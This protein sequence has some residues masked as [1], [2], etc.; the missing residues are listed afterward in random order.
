LNKQNALRYTEAIVTFIATIAKTHLKIN[1]FVHHHLRRASCSL[2]QRGEQGK[3]KRKPTMSVEQLNRLSEKTITKWGSIMSTMTEDDVKEILEIALDRELDDFSM[4]ANWYRDYQ[5]DSL[6]VV[7]LVVEVQ[8]RYGIRLPDGRMP[9]IQT[10]EAL[11]KNV[12]EILAMTPEERQRMQEEEAEISQEDM[13]MIA[14]AR[15]Q[16]LDDQAAQMTS[17]SK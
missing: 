13:E 6:A 12:E 16:V 17:A 3:G 8:K 7:A 4:E 5:M 10:G 15:Q 2:Y 1:S 14:A 11:R 9:K